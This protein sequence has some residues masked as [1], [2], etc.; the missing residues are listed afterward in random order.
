MAKIPAYKMTEE[1]IRQ[2]PHNPEYCDC[3]E[4]RHLDLVGNPKEEYYHPRDKITLGERLRAFRRIEHSHAVNREQGIPPLGWGNYLISGKK[5]DGKTTLGVYIAAELYARGYNVFHNVSAQF[6]YRVDIMDVYRLGKSLPENSVLI[7]DEIHSMLNR[8]SQSSIR[9]RNAVAGLA[10]L[11]KKQVGIIGISQQEGAINWDWRHEVDGLFYVRAGRRPSDW[12]NG[13]VTLDR[14]PGWC[15]KVIHCI[16]PQPWR[17]KLY[18]DDFG[19]DIH[20]PIQHNR[21]G[22]NPLLWYE[23]AKL[24]NSYDKPDLEASFNIR[25]DEVRSDFDSDESGMILLDDGEA[26]NPLE[27]EETPGKVFQFMYFLFKVDYDTPG[28]GLDLSR[29][30][31]SYDTMWL[32]WQ[33]L[34]ATPCKNLAPPHGDLDGNIDVEENTDYTFGQHFEVLDLDKETVCAVVRAYTDSVARGFTQQEFVRGFTM[35]YNS[36]EALAIFNR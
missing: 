29:R 8:Y 19:L 35:L 26:D 7:I 10:L 17:G 14:V 22:I 23:A 13:H 12:R 2:I 21:S 3:P 1:Q 33:R 24:Q 31:Y 4:A 5:G 25:A 11:R 28:R 9:E 6:G 15:H 30:E 20:G 27:S 16:G 18:A 36:E 34:A 32:V